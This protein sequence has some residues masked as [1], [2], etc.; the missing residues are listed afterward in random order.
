MS[1]ITDQLYVEYTFTVAPIEPW[2]DVLAAQL[3]TLG[4]ESFMETE[5][6]LL[7]YIQKDL[8]Q[9]DLLKDLEIL[10][11]DHVDIAFAKA[12]IPPTNWNH[13]WE[14]NFEAIMVDGRCEV[15]APFHEKHVVDY[16]IVIEPKMSFGTGHHQTTYMMMEHLLE[17]DFKNQKVLDMGSGTGV[18]AIL[19]Q[20]RGANAVDAVDIDTW[21]YEN[22]LENVERNKAD[23][24]TVI[25][26]GAEVLQDKF[27]DVIIANIN[28]NILL[29]DIP[30]Y[31]KC[32][33]TGGLLLLSGFYEEDLEAIEAACLQAGLEYQGHRKKDNWIAPMFLKK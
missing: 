21:C 10:Q 18:L 31:S 20:M 28:R 5:E 29:V 13:E 12:E 1:K 26:G 23:K 16:D 3:G 14:S 24:V 15:R 33:S 7:A 22:A 2:N 9:E 32:L 19:A 4:F 30:T 25:L 27:Y 11:S 17:L 8:D 6:G